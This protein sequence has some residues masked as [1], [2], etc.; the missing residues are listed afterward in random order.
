MVQCRVE[1][2]EATTELVVMA[3]EATMEVAVE[4]EEE[5][6]ETEAAQ[7]KTDTSQMHSN[8]TQE[9]H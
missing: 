2:A 4:K 1:A 7:N 9:K 6:V 5:G 3:V 8:S